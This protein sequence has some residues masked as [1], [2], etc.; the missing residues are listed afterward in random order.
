MNGVKSKLSFMM[1]LEFFIWGAWYPLIFGYLPALGFAPWQQGVILATFNVSAILAMFFSTQFVDRNFSAERFLALSHLVG[2]IAMICLVWT[3]SFPLFLALMLVH[4]LFYVPT[5]S[6]TN[7]IAFANL[8]DPQHDFGPVRLWGTIG[9]IAASWPFVFLLA[10]WAKI[11]DFGS[12][13]FVEW[14][15][16]ALGTPKEGDAAVAAT[17]FTFMTAGVASLVL[18]AFSLILPHTPPR[19]IA[20]GENKLAWLE[21]AKLLKISFIFILFIVTFFD[22]AVHQCY[23]VF[24]GR[25]YTSI[26][27]PGNWVMPVMSIGQIAEIVA[28]AFLGMVLKKLGWRTTLIIGVLGHAARFGLYA[29]VPMWQVAIA[30]NVLHGVCYAFFFATVYIFVD[31]FFPKDARASAQGLFN[32][33]ILGL[34]PIVANIG[35]PYL[36]DAF[37][38]PG[39][40]DLPAV[41]NFR[42]LFQIPM[43][44]SIGAAVLLALFFHPPAKSVPETVKH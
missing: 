28:M 21:A 35:G 39:V 5:I 14:L 18:A 13:G 2:G 34:G 40:E 31:E 44:T 4:C 20:K 17:T 1:F 38:T 42:G 30:V 7:S 9:W 23:F 22:A 26:G 6:I 3:T 11:P 10:D 41:V 43:W 33:L 15:G 16:A 32:L 25:Y 24:A 8:K 19:P 37:T 36:Y 27:I 12:V 29:F